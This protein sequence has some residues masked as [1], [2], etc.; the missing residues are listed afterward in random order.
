MSSWVTSQSVFVTSFSEEGNLLSQ[1]RAYSG[2]SGGYSI[3]F[4]R[5]YLRSVGEHFLQ[6]RPGR[7]Y[8]DSKVLAGCKYFDK[9]ESECLENDLEKLGAVDVQVG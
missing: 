2:A 4:S 3:G 9:T 1:W 6:D 5:S 7:F 8:S